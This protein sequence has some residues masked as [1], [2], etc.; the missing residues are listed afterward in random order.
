MISKIF[1]PVYSLWKRDTIRFL[2]Q[3][4][5][6]VAAIGQP[7]L[8]WLFLGI[9]F[10]TTFQ[11]PGA[12]SN[13]NYLQYFYPGILTLVILFTAIFSSFSL[14]EDKNEGFLQGVLVSPTSKT[15]LVLGKLLAGATLSLTQ[16]LFFL[17]LSPFVGFSLSP[18]SFLLLF[19][20]SFFVAFSMTGFGFCL[21]WKMDST[22]GF[23]AIMMLVLMPLWFLSGAFFPESGLPFIF[24]LFMRLNPLTYAVALMRHLFYFE[25]QK[26]LVDIPSLYLCVLVISL[27]TVLVFFTALFVTREKSC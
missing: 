23:H 21:A 18:L 20:F 27:F 16:T 4:N 5:R 19:V 10:K 8:F 14:I 17:A 9:G 25:T 7:L 15:S 6:V 12:N 24:K 11:Y 26:L 13:I 2:R 1:L 22:Q 3:K